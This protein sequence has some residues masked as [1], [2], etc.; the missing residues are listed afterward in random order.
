M[1][2]GFE[3]NEKSRVLRIG[4]NLGFYSKWQVGWKTKRGRRREGGRIL[5]LMREGDKEFRVC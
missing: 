5:G 1:I 4:G 3:W 2:L